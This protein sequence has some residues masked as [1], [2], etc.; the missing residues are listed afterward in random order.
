MEKVKEIL[1]GDFA[2]WEASFRNHDFYV[3]QNEVEIIESYADGVLAKL[4]K[5]GTVGAQEF[6]MLVKIV[7]L[8][9]RAQDGE[10]VCLVQRIYSKIDRYAMR[11][12]LD[13]G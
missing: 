11:H 12:G 7:E 6:V 9:E 3:P 5:E 8:C 10:A 2:G 4:E 1:F 13:L